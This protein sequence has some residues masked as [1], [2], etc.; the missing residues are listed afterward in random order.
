MAYVLC[1]TTLK[2]CCDRPT[3][4]VLRTMSILKR[5]AMRLLPGAGA[6]YFAAYYVFI[7][8]CLVCDV[9]SPP[10]EIR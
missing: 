10:S 8:C 1:D 4:C 3:T 6:R 9:A 5:V 7:A 2:G